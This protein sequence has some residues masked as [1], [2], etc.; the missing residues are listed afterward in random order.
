MKF[1]PKLIKFVDGEPYVNGAGLLLM[2]AEAAH[3]SDPVSA[4]GRQRARHTIN[5]LLS[6]ARAGG[7][8]QSDLLETLLSTDRDAD[9]TIDLAIIAVDCIGG[10]EALTDALK[11][12][13]FHPEGA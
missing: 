4:D 6:A 13:G 12:A 7:F 10:T 1:N 5:A 9:R 3:G 11:R 8:T 2:A